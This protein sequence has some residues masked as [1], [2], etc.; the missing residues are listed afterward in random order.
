MSEEIK[1]TWNKTEISLVKAW[2]ESGK[3]F[4]QLDNEN[5]LDSGT[6]YNIVNSIPDYKGTRCSVGKWLRKHTGTEQTPAESPVIKMKPKKK[7]YMTKKT[8]LHTSVTDS[9]KIERQL[10][11]ELEEARKKIA[12]LEAQQAKDLLRRDFLEGQLEEYRKLVTPSQSKKSP[13]K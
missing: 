2:Y 3:G 8:S 13:A 4:S 7:K 6:L 10:M 11:R 1:K 5:N 12:R 9:D